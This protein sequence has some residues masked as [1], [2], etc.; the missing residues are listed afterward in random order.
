[1]VACDD[2][3]PLQVSDDELVGTW[4]KEYTEEYWSYHADHTG[5]KWDASE[6]FSEQRPSY[7]YT[8]NIM[9]GN[10]LKYTTMGDTIN[11]P[12][13]R[14]YVITEMSEN[15]MVRE[16]ELGTYTLYRIN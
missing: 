9:D 11:V 3:T 15:R 6:G 5:A 4:K 14:I 13:T 16:E 8:W 7:S 1:M 12:I 10:R 2:D